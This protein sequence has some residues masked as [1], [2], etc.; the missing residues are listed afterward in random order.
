[1]NKKISLGILFVVG[2]LGISLISTG[3]FTGNAVSQS[4]SAYAEG[5]YQV[6]LD[7]GKYYVMF[8]KTSTTNLGVISIYKFIPNQVEELIEKIEVAKGDTKSLTNLPLQIKFTSTN[9]IRNKLRFYYTLSDVKCASG[10]S[11]S[12][13]GC[14]S[15]SSGSEVTYQGVLEMLGKCRK[16]QFGLANY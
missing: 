5:K 2:I 11:W 9:R 15:S 12:N 16:E 10:E 6:G 8:E 4:G 13:G 14:V 7:S 1:M 3:W